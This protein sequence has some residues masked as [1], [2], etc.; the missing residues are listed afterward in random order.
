MALDHEEQR[1]EPELAVHHI[2]MEEPG[3]VGFGSKGPSDVHVPPLHLEPCGALSSA[4]T[5][6]RE[7]EARSS[8]SLVACVTNC[9]FGD[10]ASIFLSFWPWERREFPP[11]GRPEREV[12]AAAMHPEEG[13]VSRVPPRARKK[14]EV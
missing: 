14:M 12:G 10:D 7:A 4:R 11:P 5:S 8:G 9:V 6:D 3:A 1:A 13:S 2:G